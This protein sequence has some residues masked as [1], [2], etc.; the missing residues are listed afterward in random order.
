MSEPVYIAAYHQ[1]KFGKLLGM[2]V[3]DILSNAVTGACR[4]I[5][6]EP[7]AMDVASVGATRWMQLLLGFIVMMTI[8][9]PQYVWTLFVPSF[10]KTT[11]ALLSDVQ[12]TITILIVLQTWLAPAQGWLVERFGPG[13]FKNIQCSLAAIEKAAGVVFD[14]VLHKA[15]MMRG[16]A[17]ELIASVDACPRPFR[18]QVAGDGVRPFVP[19]RDAVFLQPAHV[20]V[21]AQ[22]PQ[23]FDEDGPQVQ[24]LGG[25]DRKTLGQVE[26]HLMAKYT[27]SSGA[28]A[29]VF[30]GSGFKN[31]FK[32]VEIGA[33]S[34]FQ[35]KPTAE[36]NDFLFFGA[37]PF[38][39]G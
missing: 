32:K 28:G 7:A 17:V 19:D 4:E 31:C 9:S 30:A 35:F 39:C 24:L 33:H 2:T 6:T 20:G 27:Q 22:E 1:S 16:E 18:S 15:D 14:K 23:Q 5:G 36:S 26:A 21:A 11:G 8:S 37:V 25:E 29:I 34:P 13:R 10:Q 12:W 3:P 38:V